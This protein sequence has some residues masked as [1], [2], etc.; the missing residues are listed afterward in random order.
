MTM[1][2][3]LSTKP[4]ADV[5]R[6]VGALVLG[7]GRG[8]RLH[9]LTAVR[10]KPAVPLAG[11]YRLVD[12][13]LSSCIH[14]G[15]NRIHVLTQ[16]NSHSLNRHITNTYN[17]DGF[18][19]GYVEILTAEQTDKGG[20]DWFQGTADAIRKQMLHL[21]EKRFAHYLILSGDQLYRMDY[22]DLLETHLRKNADITVAALPVG[23]K[24]V[25]GFGVMQLKA[26]GRIRAF[27][28][29]PTDPKVVDSLV[30]ADKL[31]A[32]FGLAPADKPFL[33]SMGVYIFSARVLEDL[34]SAHA[35]W[36]DFGREVIPNSLRTHRVYAHLFSGFW[37]DI[38]T[39]R[40]YFD[41]SMQ[42]VRPNA[43]FEFYDPDHQIYTHRR[44]LPG[45]RIQDARVKN[46]VICDGAIIERASVQDAIIGI[47][48]RVGPGA[49]L[50][51][52]IM[53][54]SEYYEAEA[55]DTARI[56]LGIGP[57]ARIS[58][59][60]I[61]HNARIGRGVVIQGGKR[62]KDHTGEGFAI[63]DGVV[64]VHKNAIIPNG[65]RIG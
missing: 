42:L 43:P 50:K 26:D 5:M 27:V 40:S 19:N 52:V 39:V 20:D 38:G 37:E 31:F 35:E 23:R 32:E 45:V 44:A 18:S 15:I 57:D 65:T 53:L 22:R 29:K 16:F 2:T 48:G 17:F 41:V 1:S 10:A 6:S 58:E 59:A 7:G 8:T 60:I 24:D 28:E 62:L 34:L 54:G 49:A 64:I 56:P 36:V 21:R 30:T 46:A 33:A 11:R 47:R 3:P 12:I 9:P 25:A 13:P 51:R 63:R 4:S 14:S 55:A 61:D